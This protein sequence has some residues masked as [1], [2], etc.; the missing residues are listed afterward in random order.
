LSRNG[1]RNCEAIE[2]GLRQA[3]LR[4]GRLL[5]QQ[6]YAQTDLAI[7]DD[8]SRPGEKVHTGRVL[9]MHS[10]FGPVE[11][12]RNYYYRPEAGTGRFPLDEALGLE[13]S[14]SPALVRLAGG[15]RGL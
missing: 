10:I 3:L 13:G 9:Q 5:L 6:L 12:A 15:A 2:L 4:D 7:P 14:F 11:L 8:A 1:V